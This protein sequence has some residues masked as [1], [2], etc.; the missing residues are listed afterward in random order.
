MEKENQNQY[1]RT[2]IT[3]LIIA[4]ICLTVTFNMAFHAGTDR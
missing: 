3:L 4:V 2:F 1:S